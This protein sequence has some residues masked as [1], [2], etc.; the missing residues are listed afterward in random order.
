MKFPQTEAHKLF[1]LY[2]LYEIRSN[3]MSLKMC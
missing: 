2:V 3:K 1:L